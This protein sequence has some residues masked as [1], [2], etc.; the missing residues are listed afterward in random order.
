MSTPSM[1]RSTTRLARGLAAFCLA[2]VASAGQATVVSHTTTLHDGVI[3][4]FLGYYFTHQYTITTTVRHNDLHI[5][6]R[7]GSQVDVGSYGGGGTA[8]FAGNTLVITSV[9]DMPNAMTVRVDTVRDPHT[10]DGRQS[11]ALSLDGTIISSEPRTV[12]SATTP[13]G[14]SFQIGDQALA[15]AAGTFAALQ[16]ISLFQNGHASVYIGRGQSNAD[17]S[18]N[19]SLRERLGSDS[20]LL[21]G[22]NGSLLYDARVVPEPGSLALTLV[23]GLALLAGAGLRGRPGQRIS[24]TPSAC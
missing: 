10:L 8:S 19:I 3:D 12:A 21:I 1:T 9:A 17:G 11:V 7:D 2:L 18:A 24:R 5:G 22:V 6:F 15:F 14:L 4:F 20:E 13:L 23:A 16:D